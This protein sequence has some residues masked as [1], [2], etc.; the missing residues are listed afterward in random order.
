MSDTN[1][2]YLAKPAWEEVGVKLPQLMTSSE[3]MEHAGLDYKVEKRPLIP[4]ENAI[5]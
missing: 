3:A 4:W 5:G 2:I 1:M